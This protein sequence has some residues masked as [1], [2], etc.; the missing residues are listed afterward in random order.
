[1]CRGSLFG[2]SVMVMHPTRK[3]G[4]IKIIKKF[5]DYSVTVKRESA[6]V[7]QKS[8]HGSGSFIIFFVRRWGRA[9]LMI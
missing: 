8:Y 6:A 7:L 9:T 4:C 3:A 1:M 2:E 5:A